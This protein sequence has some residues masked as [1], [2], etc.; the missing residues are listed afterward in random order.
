M[1]GLITICIECNEND[2]TVAAHEAPPCREQSTTVP[3]MLPDLAVLVPTENA[4]STPLQR[5]LDRQLIVGQDVP[6][7]PGCCGVGSGL[8]RRPAPAKEGKG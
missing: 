5:S 6:N 8:D 2:L 4:A 7:G 3:F 1:L